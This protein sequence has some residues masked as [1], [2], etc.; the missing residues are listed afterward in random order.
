MMSMCS[1]TNIGCESEKGV[2]KTV[3]KNKRENTHMKNNVENGGVKRYVENRC[4]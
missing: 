4:E 3:L 2:C 1:L